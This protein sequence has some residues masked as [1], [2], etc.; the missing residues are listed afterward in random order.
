MLFCEKCNLLTEE[1]RCPLCG[2]KKLRAAEDTDFCFFVELGEFYFTMFE[3]ALNEEKIDVIGYPFYSVAVTYANAGRAGGR[4]VYIRYKDIEKAGEVYES[5]FG[6]C[7][8]G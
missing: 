6:S 3:S 5:L 7:G 2:N 4:R 8:E 1:A